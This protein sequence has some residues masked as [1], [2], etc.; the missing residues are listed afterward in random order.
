MFS[1]TFRRGLNFLIY[2]KIS[3]IIFHIDDP[4]AGNILLAG[5]VYTEEGT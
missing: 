2:E 4:F 5:W 1:S 3:T